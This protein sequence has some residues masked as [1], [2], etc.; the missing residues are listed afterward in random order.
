MMTLIQDINYI[1]DKFGFYGITFIILFFTGLIINWISKNIFPYY[2][3]KSKLEK[4]DEYKD[5]YIENNK[6]NEKTVVINKILEEEYG[7]ILLKE[8]SVFK[9][10]IMIFLLYYNL[11]RTI[12]EAKKFARYLVFKELQKSLVFN[13]YF[14]LFSFIF[15]MILIILSFCLF[16]Y[17]KLE[18]QKISENFG[19][20]IWIISCVLSYL[21]SIVFTMI[22]TE[23][24]VN[25]ISTF[26][27]IKKNPEAIKTISVRLSE[28]NNYE[29]I[30][31]KEK[32][33]TQVST[34]KTLQKKLAIARNKIKVEKYQKKA[35]VIAL[36]HENISINKIA[37]IMGTTVKEIEKIINKAN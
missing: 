13:T 23:I 31:K 33:S 24:L 21:L 16:V 18:E 11:C 19:F 27:L 8:R 9:Q 36:Y 25:S 7:R 17:L 1:I 34:I 12:K 32:A 2:F 26:N 22:N 14:A 10:K 3:R 6:F 5:K 20:Y 35:L 28:L 15:M 30:D 29:I 4:L 37:K